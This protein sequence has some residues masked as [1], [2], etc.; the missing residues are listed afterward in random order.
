MIISTVKNYIKYFKMKERKK[1]YGTRNGDVTYYVIRRDAENAGINSYFITNL[2]HIVWGLKHG[3]VPIVDMKNYSNA[4]LKNNELGEKNAWEYY[5]NQPAECNV[6]LEEVYKSKNVILSSG[7]APKA[8]P[9]DSMDFFTRKETMILWH[10]YFVH[11]VGF[12]KVLTDEV[13]I[14][15][16]KY[17]ADKLIRGERILCVSLRGCGYWNSR[18]YGHPVQPTIEQAIRKTYEVMKQYNC[19]WVYLATEDIEIENKYTDEFK[20]KLIFYKERKM[21]KDLKGEDAVY[22]SFDRENDEYLKGMEYEVQMILGTYCNCF[23]GG[24]TSGNVAAMVFN[25]YYDYTYFWNLG[26]YGIDDTEYNSI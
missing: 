5:F 21:Y 20:D 14:Y 2:G 22:Y 19:Q 13:T 1:R 26:R 3:W 18:P 10:D 17:L 25:P 12:S 7:Y 9:S 11:H 15:Y 6:S 8:Y 4:Y 23:I 24:R 16:N